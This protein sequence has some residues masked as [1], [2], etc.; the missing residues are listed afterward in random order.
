[1]SL[2]SFCIFLFPRPVRWV[3]WFHRHNFNRAFRF[4]FQFLVILVVYVH[5]GF[6]EFNHFT[7]DV[8]L[9]EQSS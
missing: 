8:F 5:E 9:G 1:M 6:Q 4:G 3:D 2:N 7:I